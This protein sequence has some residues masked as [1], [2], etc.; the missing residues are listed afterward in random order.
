MFRSPSRIVRNNPR[1][2][3]LVRGIFIVKTTAATFYRT[4][5]AI[6]HLSDQ[7]IMTIAKAIPSQLPTTAVISNGVEGKGHESQYTS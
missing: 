2:Y 4:S 6:P 7:H 3:S 1:C 5:A